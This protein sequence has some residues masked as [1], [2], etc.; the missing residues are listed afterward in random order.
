MKRF[1]KR[2]P[3]VLLALTMLAFPAALAEKEPADQIEVMFNGAAVGF[4]D[5]LPVIAGS[6][7]WEETLYLP[8]RALM[9]AMGGDVGFENGLVTATYN[10]KTLAF[11]L[12]GD[13]TAGT[14]TDEDVASPYPLDPAPML[15]GG[16]TLVAA[17]TLRDVF[18][19]LITWDRTF[20]Y[21]ELT[22]EQMDKLEEANRA[23]E[24]ALE[25]LL[26]RYYRGEIDW[27]TLDAIWEKLS[28]ELFVRPNEYTILYTV[29]VIDPSSLLD[30]ID[31]RFTVLNKMLSILAAD[32]P[33]AHTGA[34]SGTIDIE[35]PYL[36]EYGLP[37][38]MSLPLEAALEMIFSGLNSSGDAKLGLN[39]DAFL[40]LLSELTGNNEEIV[41][42]MELLKN[43]ALSYVFNVDKGALYL[44][45]PLFDTIYETAAGAWIALPFGNEAM[46]YPQPASQIIEW[47]IRLSA[48]DSYYALEYTDV[49]LMVGML[50]MLLG[51]GSFAVSGDADAPVYTLEL[52]TESLLSKLYGMMDAAGVDFGYRNYEEF[53]EDFAYDF[54]NL[55]FALS[56]SFAPGG[57]GAGD[58]V[59]AAL[60]FKTEDRYGT[61]NEMDLMIDLAVPGATD[62]S[63]LYRIYDDW[64]GEAVTIDLAYKGSAAPFDGKVPS[65]P[66]EGAVILDE[67]GDPVKPIEEMMTMLMPA[68]LAA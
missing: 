53:K 36:E 32:K 22:P 6:G 34:L 18:G 60:W 2:A 12:N 23:F 52:N 30:G 37:G 38:K 62:L 28:E 63:L 59:S 67:Y 48:E 26:E 29:S 9:D 56:L 7:R 8:L 39:L 57:N 27:Y 64:S 35:I 4:S 31:G 46:P 14:V 3:A 11:D 47:I 24:E 17:E 40:P 49:K 42:V 16:R 45:S 55:D 66:P 50:E 33:M 58:R 41:S 10:G 65:A 21:M 54:D 15:I 61:L 5:A 51:D 13:R 44:Q 43:V 20:S 19:L 1:R 68:A 25:K